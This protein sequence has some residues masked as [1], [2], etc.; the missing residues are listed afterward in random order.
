MSNWFLL[1][2][3]QVLLLLPIEGGD[4][5]QKHESAGRPSYEAGKLRVWPQLLPFLPTNRCGQKVWMVQTHKLDQSPV[6]NV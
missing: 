6:W 1:V 5:I 3:K 4:E 2:N